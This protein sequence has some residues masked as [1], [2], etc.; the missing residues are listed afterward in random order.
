MAPQTRKSTRLVTSSQNSSTPKCTKKSTER[1]QHR[2]AAIYANKT[3]HDTIK[4]RDRMRKALALQSLNPKQLDEMRDKWRQKQQQRRLKL[5]R[6]NASTP[7]TST[8]A[9]SSPR[10]VKK[11]VERKVRR[12]KD[13][14]IARLQNELESVRLELSLITKD[15]TIDI[16]TN[17]MNTDSNS[18]T[19]SEP[20]LIVSQTLWKSM[21][22]TSKKRTKL[23][24]TQQ[25]L[26]RGVAS[27]MRGL[28]LNLSK[29]IDAMPSTSSSGI[30]ESI[31]TFFKQDDVT[32]ICPDKK[33]VITNPENKEEQMPAHYRL[34]SLSFLHKKFTLQQGS[35]CVYSTFMRHVPYYVIKPSPQSWGTCMCGTCLNPELKLVALSQKL[36]DQPISDAEDLSTE[37]IPIILENLAIMRSQWKQEEEEESHQDKGRRTE[38]HHHIR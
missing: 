18:D 6:L 32:R 19:E 24:L 2:R 13:I 23:N 8:C 14:E 31:H 3:K 29:S 28:G 33:A 1:S 4:E 36:K 34:S 37:T 30:E 15:T 16:T 20:D 5:K 26:P 21:T 22:P 38:E 7:S 17:D 25:Q 27:K 10:R 35:Q 11:N 9:S 12:K